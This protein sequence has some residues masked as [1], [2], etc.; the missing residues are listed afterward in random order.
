MAGN[1]GTPSP[2]SILNWLLE[3]GNPSVRYVALR[4][5]LGKTGEDL[6]MQSVQAAIMNQGL[7]PRVLDKQNDDG[8]WAVPEKFYTDKYKGAVWNLLLL[9]ELE[10]DPADARV[11]KACE[12][13]LQ[14]AQHPE[15]GGFSFAESVRSGGGLA[16]GVIPCLSGNMAYSLIKLGFLDD[17]R[18][19]RAID[20]IVTV[21]RADDGDQGPPLGEVY[22]RF[23]TCWGSHSCHMGVAKALKA[24]VAIPP[25]RRT[26]EIQS[27]ID[28]F[29][30]YFLIHHLYKKSHDLTQMSKPGWL[31]LGFPQMYQTDILELLEIFADLDL[32]DPR[33]SDAI[34]VL[35]QKRQ[36]DGLWKLDNSLN[37][38]TL[39]SIEKRVNRPNGSP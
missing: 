12:F 23:Y 30:E 13:I 21:A 19:Q 25:E 3:P 4:D 33:L 16:S 5:L 31:R 27:K 14:H 11:H 2:D 7:V 17:Q 32:F 38:R 20:W 24:L 8:S 35:R 28:D 34:D 1:P 39:V 6:E 9:A 36:A 10:A 18:V 22:Q 26:S 29:A 37:G 15:S